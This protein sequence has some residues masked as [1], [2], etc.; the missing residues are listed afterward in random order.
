MYTWFKDLSKQNF[1]PE[2]KSIRSPGISMT[3]HYHGLNFWFFS[4]H[5]PKSQVIWMIPRKHLNMR[6]MMNWTLLCYCKHFINQWEVRALQG[7]SQSG[8]VLKL[9]LLS[10]APH[11]KFKVFVHRWLC[12][13]VAKSNFIGHFSN[14]FQKNEYRLSLSDDLNVIS[15]FRFQD[16]VHSIFFQKYFCHQTNKY[17]IDT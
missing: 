12:M 4:A 16:K 6:L 2:V 17:N 15:S 8:T 14:A 1:G 9:D 13:Q 11:G 10:Q 3:C 5:H 7:S